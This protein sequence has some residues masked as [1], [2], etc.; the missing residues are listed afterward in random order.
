MKD[1]TP[2]VV[3]EGGVAEREGEEE[4]DMEA[5]GAEI[6]TET[7]ITLMMTVVEG[8]NEENF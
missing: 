1:S 6:E 7:M 5:A 3:E 8:G 4:G 2:I